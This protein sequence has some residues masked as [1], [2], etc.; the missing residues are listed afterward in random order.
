MSNHTST[1][2]LSRQS[3]EATMSDF[4]EASMDLMSLTQVL[5]N[6]EIETSDIGYFHLL[7]IA[8]MLLE[9]LSRQDSVCA[10]SGN[11]IVDFTVVVGE[12]LR[13]LQHAAAEYKPTDRWSELVAGGIANTA[14]QLRTK[15]L[16]A[17]QNWIKQVALAV[18]CAAHHANYRLQFDHHHFLHD[19]ESAIQAADQLLVDLA[20]KVSNKHVVSN[21]EQC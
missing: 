10:V 11:E 19:L 4:E 2:L 17:V 9:S 15:H 3:P 20:L 21:A 5:Y 12:R 1:N 16:E 13:D 7:N 6:M 14:G 18:I 8:R